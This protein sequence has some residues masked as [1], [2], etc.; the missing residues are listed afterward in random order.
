MLADL[1][2]ATRRPAEAE[3]PLKTVADVSTD[4]AAKLRLADYFTGLGRTNEATVLLTALSAGQTTFAEAELRLASIE[5]G[6]RQSREAHKRVD[7]LLVRVPNNSAA[8]TTKAEWLIDENKLDEALKFATAAVAAAPQSALAHFALATI[9][10]R[11]GEIDAAIKSYNEVTRLN[12]R[13]DRAMTALSR[14]NLN[15]DRE[16]ALRQAEE[17]RQTAPS[18]NNARVAL[19]RGLIAA[20]NVTRAE[21]ELSQL[22]AIA[23]GNA[24]VLALQGTLDTARGNAAAAR[25]SFERALAL[26]PGL[27]EAL[28]GLTYLDLHIKQTRQAIARLEAAVANQ[29]SSPRLVALL[30]QAYLAAGDQTKAEQA[31][32]RAVSID[33]RFTAG[34][35]QLA[36]MF[37]QQGKLEQARLEFEGIA[38]RD[39]SAI[40]AKTFVGML[41]DIQGRRDEARRWYEELVKGTDDAPV[42][43]NNL[44]F[45]YA[46][47]GANLDM[48]L[49]LATSAKPK[50]PDDPNV[51]DTIGWVYYKKG[52]HSLAVGPLE[53]S[54]KKLPRNAEVLYHL[55]LTYAALGEKA[56]ARDTLS[57]AISLNPKVGGEQVRKALAAVSQ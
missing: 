24:G 17:A 6:Q 19:V 44:A 4:P 3:Q 32:R 47:Q 56:K 43:A 8:L 45:M 34:Y 31:L 36:Q 30:A 11:R 23:P 26:S 42:A 48:A 14:L 18:N 57:L 46:D 20:G 37:V 25:Q 5:R 39:P 1:Y 28:N 55:G 38:R 13:A 21:A 52:L 16:L 54:A 2:L 33:P 9:H 50:L 41:L 35:E 29:S 22:R 15:R 53:A 51:D 49:Q 7:A 40:G 10:E 12:P 27:F